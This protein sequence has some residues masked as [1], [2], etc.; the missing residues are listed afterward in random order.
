VCQKRRGS[1]RFLPFSFRTVV[2]FFKAKVFFHVVF[3]LGGVFD[4]WRWSRRKRRVGVVGWVEFYVRDE[5]RGIRRKG[6]KDN[7]CR[8]RYVYS[9]L[10]QQ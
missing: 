9:Q 2:M 10:W 7:K 5:A 8:Q 1:N 6:M 3:S 4:L